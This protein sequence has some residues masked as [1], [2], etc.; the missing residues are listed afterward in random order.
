MPALTPTEPFAPPRMTTR[1]PRKSKKPPRVTTNDGILSRAAKVPWMAPTTP[2]HARATRMA[3][4]HG[5]PGLGRWTS[6]KAMTPPRRATAPM[7]RS[8][9]PRSRTTISAIARTM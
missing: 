2:Q 3:A 7:D 5:Q 1:I 6:W 8:I 9:S 4:H